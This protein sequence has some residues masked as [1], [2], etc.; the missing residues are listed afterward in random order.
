MQPA[1]HISAKIR[2]IESSFFQ[3]IGCL[4]LGPSSPGLRGAGLRI[5]P[6]ERSQDSSNFLAIRWRSCCNTMSFSSSAMMRSSL[7]ALSMR[8]RLARP[9]Y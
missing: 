1:Q 9:T 2:E 3:L 5:K 7:S 6:G 8:S 4:G